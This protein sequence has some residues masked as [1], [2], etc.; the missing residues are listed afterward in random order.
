M[1]QREEKI[2]NPC[3][4]NEEKFP[5]SHVKTQEEPSSMEPVVLLLGGLRQL[6]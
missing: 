1:C 4:K 6:L 3:E 5:L 2:A